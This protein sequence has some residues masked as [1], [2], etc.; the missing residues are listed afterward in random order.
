MRLLFLTTNRLRPSCRYRI[1]QYLPLFAR[2]GVE[3]RVRE[4]SRAGE[5]PDT[6]FAA[7]LD[8]A[9]S[10]DI[11]VLSRA[12][13]PRPR[14]IALRRA[15]RRLVFDFDDAVMLRE[16]ASAGPM[17]RFSVRRLLGFARVARAADLLIAGN[18]FLRQA[19]GLVGA[20]KKCA[21]V[22]TPVA[23]DKF[24]AAR[25]ARASR[26]VEAGREAR[27]V[28]VG[29]VGSRGTAPYLSLAREGVTRALALRRAR[30]VMRVI[31]DGFPDWP[32]TPVE[33]VPW[34]A[35]G[36]IERLAAL[37]VGLAPLPD[38]L[39]TRGKC[40]YK[41]YQYLAAGIPVVASPVGPHRAIIERAGGAVVPATRPGEWSAALERLIDDPALRADL[42]ARGARF[43]ER[44]GPE[45][46]SL[47]VCADLLLRLFSRLAPGGIDESLLGAT[48][49][50]LFP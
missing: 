18:R 4:I 49:Y 12:L 24:A 48:G 6:E 38:D 10:A 11:V 21:V 20:W 34:S 37:D 33:R 26:E 35:E 13:L 7:A 3:A 43:I 15:A 22:P 30:A 17:R 41:V 1:L 44:G 23:A 2:A 32:E 8:E 31:S 42:G 36:E 5:S 28:V 29:W 39:W 19:A 40:G 27:A 50:A 25:A 46:V 45:S 14:L 16:S 9:A 47:N